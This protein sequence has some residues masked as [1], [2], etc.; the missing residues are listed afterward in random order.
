MA[1]DAENMK[2]NR[3]ENRTQSDIN[4]RCYEQT[5]EGNRIRWEPTLAATMGLS[6]NGKMK[7]LVGRAAGSELAGYCMSARPSTADLWGAL[8]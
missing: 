4:N 1:E 3:A 5:V 8:A 2:P 6:L 7:T